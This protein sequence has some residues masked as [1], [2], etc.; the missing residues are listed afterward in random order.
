M[1][2][3]NNK[4]FLIVISVLLLPLLTN[5]AKNGYTEFYDDYG[6][7]D[8]RVKINSNPEIYSTSKNNIDEDI[9]QVRRN[10]YY[11]VGHS[12]FTGASDNVHNATKAAIKKNADLV[13]YYE[14]FM[15]SSTTNTSMSVPDTQT[16]Y[17][18]GSV[19]SSGGYGSYSGTSTTYGT[20]QV[21]I[22]ITRHYYDFGAVFFRQFKMK[23]RVGFDSDHCTDQQKKQIQK[24]QC[25]YITLI[26]NDTPAYRQNLMEGDIFMSINGHNV[27]NGE[28]FDRA[29][30]TTKNEN[31]LNF[32]MMRNS[33][34]I[35]IP[36]DIRK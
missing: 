1:E 28:S 4:L 23:P 20:R 6:V 8:G 10:N 7:E 36:V 15:N 22:S 32:K 17:H 14:E 33:K 35:N 29:I 19:N 16:S 13:L 34:K 31:V 11:T 26:F 27:Y 21:P 25:W 24:N 12:F 9:K 30:N 3:R 18:S 2:S 5:C